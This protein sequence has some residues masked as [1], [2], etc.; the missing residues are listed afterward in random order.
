MS[1]QQAVESWV[2]GSEEMSSFVPYLFFKP[3]FH[4]F[5]T[6]HRGREDYQ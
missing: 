1:T 5:Q 3:D 6:K 2:W 4:S